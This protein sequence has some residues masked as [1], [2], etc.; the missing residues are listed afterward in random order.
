MF[1]HRR[2]FPL[3]FI[4]FAH[5]DECPVAWA[6]VRACVCVSVCVCDSFLFFSWISSSWIINQF[7]LYCCKH[8]LRG[9]SGISPVHQPTMP[10]QMRILIEPNHLVV[11][12]IRGSSNYLSF[13][14]SSP[15]RSASVSNSHKIYSNLFIIRFIVSWNCQCYSM[16]YL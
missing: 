15:P 12:F 9:P 5:L 14:S 3:R 10:T 8:W 11:Q 7:M 13:D 6:A 2:Y 4:V 16:N 1:L